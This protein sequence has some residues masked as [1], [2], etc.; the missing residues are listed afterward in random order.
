VHT[1]THTSENR[2]YINGLRSHRTESAEQNIFV[3]AAANAQTLTPRNWFRRMDWTA[4][5]TAAFV[6]AV[7]FAF[8]VWLAR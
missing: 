2:P 6:Y 8:W 5:G 3:V 4:I 1:Q 7:A